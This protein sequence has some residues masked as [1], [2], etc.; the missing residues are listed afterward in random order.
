MM[1]S[2]LVVVAILL[3]VGSL[4]VTAVAQSQGQSKVQRCVALGVKASVCATCVVAGMGNDAQD[5]GPCFCKYDSA[6]LAQFENMGQC[7]KWVQA[8]YR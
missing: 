8:N 7:V 2:Y 5:Y 6:L 1:R 3:L 4:S